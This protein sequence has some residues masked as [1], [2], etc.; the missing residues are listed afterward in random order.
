MKNVIYSLLVLIVITTGCNVASQ[1]GDNVQIRVSNESTYPLQNF[2]INTGG[3]DN[4]YGTIN[5]GSK[6]DYASYEY[7]YNYF[8]VSV[9]IDTST[10]VIQPIDYVGESKIK[11]G[12]YTY[13]ISV[14]TV[15]DQPVSFTGQ[16][17]KD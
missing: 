4:T 8:Y 11:P 6:S 15:G 10:F 9:D 5:A 17:R 3:G 14:E 2:R 13:S 1:D 16:L 12:K 7:S